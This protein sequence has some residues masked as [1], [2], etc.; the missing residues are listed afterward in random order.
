MRRILEFFLCFPLSNRILYFVAI[1]SGNPVVAKEATT[2]AIWSLTENGDCW[3]HWNNLYKENLEA[4]VALL[5]KLVNEWKDHSL[6]LLSSPSVGLTL[7]R[8]MKSFW[9]KNKKAITEGGAN[10]S[11]HEEADEYLTSK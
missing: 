1:V 3:D 11:L 4:S 10:S 8:T 9:L 5:R 6:K 2:I 7:S